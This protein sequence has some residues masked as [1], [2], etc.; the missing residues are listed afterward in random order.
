M[1]AS[2]QPAAAIGHGSFHLLHRGAAAD[3]PSWS[4]NRSQWLLLHPSPHGCHDAAVA[5]QL[6]ERGPLLPL[7]AASQ[8]GE[9][10]TG[11]AAQS[12]FWGRLFTACMQRVRP[13]VVGV[14]RLGIADLGIRIADG[15]SASCHSS[16]QIGWVAGW[17]LHL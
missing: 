13:F 10:T 11:T 17:V 7:H 6:P 1:T 2:R 16:H 12:Q 14:E 4:P 8:W 9:G 15:V 3:L 5:L